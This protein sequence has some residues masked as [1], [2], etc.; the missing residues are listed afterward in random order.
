[1]CIEN[2]ITFVSLTE[3]YFGLRE[4]TFNVHQLTHLAKDVYDSGPLWNHSCF[5]FE[6][7]NHVLVRSVHSGNGVNV[8]ILRYL[9]MCKCLKILEVSIAKSLSESFIKLYDGL[10]KYKT[11]NIYRGKNAIYF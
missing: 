6:S 11:E 9:G 4:M 2:F 5:A 7:S 8:Q 1:M 3:A 10:G